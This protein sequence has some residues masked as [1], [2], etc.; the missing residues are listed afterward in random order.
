MQ[1]AYPKAPCSCTVYTWALK[2]YVYT[3][4]LH[5]AFG[6]LADGPPKGGK[7]STPMFPMSLATGAPHPEKA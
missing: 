4:Q 5:G 3:M 6:I 2:V 7:G 1:A